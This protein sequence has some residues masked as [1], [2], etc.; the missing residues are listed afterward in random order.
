MHHN[1]PNPDTAEPLADYTPVE[2]STRRDGWTAERQRKFLEALAESGRVAVAAQV[3]GL[4][5]R[6]AY[7]LRHHPQGRRF[8]EAWDAA[9]YCGA[10]R[11]IAIALERA[12]VG[13]YREVWKDGRIQSEVR[14]PSD[15][16]LIYLLNN[17]APHVFSRGP[18][19]HRQNLVGPAEA[20]T[21]PPLHAERER[22]MAKDPYTG[23]DYDWGDDDGDWM[24]D[25]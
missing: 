14:A 13:G 2:I 19:K 3:V 18:V 4:S 16:L 20:D 10:N 15:K 8:A 24:D 7:R 25:E 11:L 23:E 12:T 9:L 6:S 1:P 22:P 17:L 5:V 21:S